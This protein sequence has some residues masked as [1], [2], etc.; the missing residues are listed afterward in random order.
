MQ[1]FSDNLYELLLAFSVQNAMR[2]NHL[3]LAALEQEKANE[4]VQKLVDK[5]TVS[6]C[7]FDVLA[8]DFLLSDVCC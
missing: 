3:R 6:S 2:T 1:K 5:Q 7:S 8:C 4:N